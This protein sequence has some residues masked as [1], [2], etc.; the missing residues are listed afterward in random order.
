MGQAAK[1]GSGSR[2]SGQSVEMTALVSLHAIPDHDLARIA[3]MLEGAGISGITPARVILSR[4]AAESVA[5]GQ[6]ATVQATIVSGKTVREPAGQPKP[7]ALTQALDA[8]RM[9]GEGFKQA[10]LADPD[11]LSTAD[12]AGRLGMSEEGV[13]LKRKRH[14]VL[15]LE[16]AKR[17]I[18]YP[19]WQVTEHRQLLPMLPRLFEILGDS[20]WTIYRF[21]LQHHA[22]LDGV[23][24][25]DALRR[26]HVGRVIAAAEN[27]ASG[28]FS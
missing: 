10:L 14:E 4:R 5:S 15:G 16:L 13:R 1:H 3:T 24:A 11:M 18:R 25:L 27:V 8:A 17:G 28:G 19:D 21:L 23:R 6:F 12:M 7:S 20:P 22:E 2:Q 26:G 9:R